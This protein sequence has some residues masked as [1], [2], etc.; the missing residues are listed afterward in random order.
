MHFLFQ[1]QAQLNEEIMTA[2][3]L[4]DEQNS[5]QIQRKQIDLR[6]ASINEQ[7]QEVCFSDYFFN[8]F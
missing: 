7:Q 1:M 6:L 4:R 8:S 5:L 2:R 3:K